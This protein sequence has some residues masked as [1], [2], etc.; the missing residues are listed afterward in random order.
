MVDVVAI[1]LQLPVDTYL[2]LKQAAARENRPEGAVVVTAIEAYLD[3]QRGDDPLLGLFADEAE[4]V[5]E[6]VESAMRDRE[7]TSLRL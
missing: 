7:C 1:E 3:R 4:L 5:D 2:A 6:I